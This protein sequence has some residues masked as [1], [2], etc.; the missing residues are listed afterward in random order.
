MLAELPVSDYGAWAE[1]AAREP[2]GAPA[3]DARIGYMLSVIV[4]AITGERT[5][6]EDFTPKWGPPAQRAPQDWQDMRRIVQ[7]W[8]K[9]AHHRKN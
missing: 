3:W 2:F 9:D 6:A 4:G 1:F 8:K 7:S 5:R